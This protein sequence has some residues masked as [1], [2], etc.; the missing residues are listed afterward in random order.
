VI[1]GGGVIGCS[2]AYHLTKL[3]WQDVVLLE[4]KK[5]TSGTTWHAA[6]LI[7]TVRANESHAR[8]TE[9]SMR[10]LHDLETE[11]GQSTGFRQVGSLSIAHSEDRWQELRRVAAMNNAFGVTEVKLVTSEEVKHLFPLIDD[12]DIIG[13]TW[14]EHDGK[15]NPVEITTAFIKGA[16]QKGAICIEGVRVD[17]VLVENGKV[18]AVV[19]EQGVIQTDFV[20]NCSGM[21]AREL[22]RKSGINIPLHACEHYYAV[23]E[24]HADVT[25]DLPVLRDH[26]KCVYIKEDAGGLL[27]GAFEKRAV[28]WGRQG[29]PGDFSFDELPGH[30]EQQLMPVLEDAML[31]VPMLADVGWRSFFCGP[32]SFTPDDQFHVGEVPEVHGY[33]VAAGLNSV[34]RGEGTLGP[35][36]A[37][38]LVDAIL[39]NKRIKRMVESAGGGEVEPVLITINSNPEGADVEID[40]VYLGNAGGEFEVNPGVHEIQVSLPGFETWSKKVKVRDG[41]SFTATLSEAVD[42]KIEIQVEQ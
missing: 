16:R 10:L 9:Y 14:V 11:T 5:L 20:V 13:G 21:W 37:A 30:L 38:K 32:E 28:A 33:F 25:P 34:G 31:R 39:N 19:T 36:V 8:L 24:K 29:I 42:Q 26:D 27:V 4:R 12:K 15:A 1:I 35:N 7:G 22:G 41:L 17:D 18:R 3:G 23:T 2:V 6:G 40:G